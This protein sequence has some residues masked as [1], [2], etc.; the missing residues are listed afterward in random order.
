[1]AIHDIQVQV[2]GARTQ[3]AACLMRSQATRTRTKRPPLR[4]K[5][6]LQA[7]S[8]SLSSFGPG[9]LTEILFKSV[10]PEGTAQNLLQ[11]KIASFVGLCGKH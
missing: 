2:V 4:S 10:T 7:G 6:C 1:M 3:G 9:G 11:R 8:S 5:V